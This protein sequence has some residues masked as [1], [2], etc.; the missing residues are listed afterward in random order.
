MSFREKITLGNDSNLKFE[1]DFKISIL[2]LHFEE[3]TLKYNRSRR[4]FQ[5]NGLIYKY[6]TRSTL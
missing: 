5:I 4:I 1:N 2:K 6:Y 3:K